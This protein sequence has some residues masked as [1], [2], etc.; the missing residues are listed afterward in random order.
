ME[1]KN[2]V[3]I[4]KKIKLFE[5]IYMYKFVKA[6][7]DVRYNAIEDTIEYTK[8][9][10]SQKIYNMEDLD[11]TISDEKYCFSDLLSKDCVMETAGVS[12]EEVKETFI[13]DCCTFV[14]FGILD[15]EKENLKIVDSS[16]ETL[17]KAKPDSHYI[18]YCLSYQT[19]EGTT[20]YMSVDSL[21]NVLKDVDSGEL[22]EVKRFL[23]EL[24]TNAEELEEHCGELEDDKELNISKE[25]KQEEPDSKETTSEK[26]DSLIGLKTI[27]KEVMKLNNFL[28]FL[29][30]VKDETALE[31][32]N[33]NMVFLGN[34][35]TGKTTVAKIIATMFHELG[36]AQSVSVAE[37]TV[38]DFIAEYVGQTA[39]KAKEVI[40]K[41]KG[42]VIFIDEA[43]AFCSDGQMYAQEALVEIIKEMEKKETIF[44]F[45]GYKKE[46]ND[47]IKINPGLK[48]RIGY[49]LDFP[50]YSLDELYDIFL[51]KVNLSKLKI[52]D[53]IGAKV[54][55]IISDF[56]NKEHFGNGRFIDKLFDKILLSHANRCSDSDD[57]EVLKT[58]TEEDINVDIK[59]E[60][61]VKDNK[62]KKIGY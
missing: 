28:T 27:K 61:D 4:Y 8:K 23:Q 39:V 21:K 58:L 54:K 56:M 1:E 55:L 31:Q 7:E 14:R 42:G 34:P 17:K 13:N 60:L 53:K 16:L 59:E 36:Y 6:I 26:L 24:I 11:F 2:I 18:D 51:R 35:G 44:I 38:Q 46:M 47:F 37:L 41:Y 20:V 22:G 5:N 49:Y 25:T 43:Y 10:K 33:L 50:D 19:D 3:G 15:I 62:T 12:A 40:K 30:K 9:N 29:N 57:L 45:A 52:D 48:S 32:P